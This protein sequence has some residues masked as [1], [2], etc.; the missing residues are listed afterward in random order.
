MSA[1]ITPEQAQSETIENLIKMANLYRV[2]SGA[3]TVVVN[4]INR[5]EE[6]KKMIRKVLLT[7]CVALIGLLFWW[8]RALFM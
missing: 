4:E 5:R 6:I 3:H 2:G 1:D 8:L 7:V